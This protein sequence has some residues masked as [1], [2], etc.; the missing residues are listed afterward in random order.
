MFQVPGVVSVTVN[1]ASSSAKVVYDPCVTG[2][3][4]C[5]EAVEDAGEGPA[6]LSHV[7]SALHAQSAGLMHTV[8]CAADMS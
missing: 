2:P 6:M 4:S 5:I 1:L 3:R 7:Y 8:D